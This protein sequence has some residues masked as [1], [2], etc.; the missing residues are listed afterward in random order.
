[1][2]VN[3]FLL[4]NACGYRVTCASL[5]A[6]RSLR[7]KVLKLPSF[8]SAVRRSTLIHPV[9]PTS[10]NG[11]TYIS[12]TTAPLSCT[13]QPLLVSPS[14]GLPEHALLVFCGCEQTRGTRNETGA[15][16]HIQTPMLST[17]PQNY[18]STIP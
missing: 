12:G 11:H 9:P 5:K 7:H 10:S 4:R 14:Y 18:T 6:S 15:Y 16:R 1:M 13:A 17:H 3:F 8:L 2:P